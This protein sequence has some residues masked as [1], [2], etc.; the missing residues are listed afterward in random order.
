ME[1]TSSSVGSSTGSTTE[2]QSVGDVDYIEPTPVTKSTVVSNSASPG[3][4]SH[5]DPSPIISVT[6]LANHFNSGDSNPETGVF[7]KMENV[8]NSR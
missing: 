4:E 3:L 7:Q 5:Y 1:D 2:M 8:L 6:K